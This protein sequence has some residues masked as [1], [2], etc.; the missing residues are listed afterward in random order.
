MTTLVEDV[1][2][3][4]KSKHELKKARGLRA[5]TFLQLA[6]SNSIFSRVIECK[7]TKQFWDKLS[8]EFERNSRLKVVKHFTLKR[9]FEKLRM[10]KKGIH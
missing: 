7:T 8:E 3:K 4:A 9:Q 2:E 6:V 10:K 1:D 5:L